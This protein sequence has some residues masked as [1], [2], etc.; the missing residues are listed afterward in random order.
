MVNP[1]EKKMNIRRW[2]WLSAILLII[3]MQIAAARLAATLWTS[4]LDIVEFMAFLGA[5]LGLAL[6]KSIFKRFWVVIFAIAY[7]SF[8]IPWQLGLTL[9][10]DATWRERLI[11]LWD[12][13][14]TVIEE[15]LTRRPVT[16]SLLFLLLMALLFWALTIYSSFVLVRQDN[17]WKVI[18]PGG[19]AT[20]VIHSFDPLL[21]SRSWYLAFYLFF[22]LILVARIVFLKNTVKW[23]Q[24]HT[25]TPPDIGFDLS[26]VALVLS[27]ILVFFSWNVPVLADT[28]RPA[29]EM[30]Q[31][32]SR[33]WLTA[34]DRFSFMFA[35][36][37]ASVGLVE[38]YYG[39]TM[40][41]GLGNPL[42]DQVVMEIRAPSAPPNGGRFYWEARSYDTYLANQWLTSLTTTHDLT[43]STID[44]SQ[45][46]LAARLDLFFTFYPYVPISNLFVAP[47]PLWVSIPTRAYM[48]DNPDGT[49]NFGAL[50]TRGIVHPGEQ[51]SM[52]AAVDA[53][54]IRQLKDAGTIYPD[55][56]ANNYLQLPESITP[57]T[58]ELARNIASGLSNPYDIANAITNYL[59]QNIEYN[60][61][62]SNPPANQDRIDWFLFDY[63]KGYCLYY[64]SAEV[65]ML[66]S[67]GI[68]ARMAVGYA[69]GELEPGSSQEIPSGVSTDITHPQTIETSIYVV[70][71]KD[72]HAWP[73]VFFPEIGWVIFEPTVSQPAF[74]RPSGEASANPIINRPLPQEDVG[75]RQLPQDRFGADSAV[76]NGSNNGFFAN[77]WTLG[78]II[79][80]ILM[81]VALAAL[82]VVIRQVRR[83]FRVQPFLE[84]LSLDIPVGIDK[85]L[86]KLGI[87]PPDFLVNWIYYRTLPVISRSYLEI[88]RALERVGKGPSIQDT[89]SER[90]HALV[91]AMPSAYA[92]A[93]LLSREYQ[94]SVYST[95]P[96]DSEGAQKAGSEI[97]KLSWQV[98]RDRLLAR[99]K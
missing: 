29:A 6:G 71:Q 90:A 37:R 82:V 70:R 20:F 1:V 49:V 48:A 4:H 97:R 39:P 91:D 14:Q 77:F 65:V 8:F 55:W 35:S 9:D 80:L 56:V 36:L 60:Q 87:R 52:R 69:Q 26:R 46:G 92:P 73:E 34:K 50:M 2:D 31:T 22:A 16:D 5:I 7:G 33:P 64:A 89:P 24:S 86:R 47:E 53:M 27:M 44:L 88:N 21:V 54:T 72:A 23:Q 19:V 18:I 32:A 62:V 10:A 45:P 81:A 3:I 74:T 30:W 78:N 68:P 57:R 83:G 51:Y 76:K 43:P 75:P 66:R 11:T 41:L 40:S 38:N 25:H 84:R 93:R 15:L 17:P 96:A 12:R 13:L 98:W 95:H 58:R 63:K 94:K 28:F 42:S 99:F 61:S 85:G 79:R 59:R 67:L